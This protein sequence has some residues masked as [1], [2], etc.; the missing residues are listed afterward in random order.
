MRGVINPEEW[1]KVPGRWH[2][3]VEGARFGA[4]ISV[5]FF[6]KP[7]IGAAPA[8]IS[9]PIRKHSSSAPEGRCSRLQMK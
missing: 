1:A 3:E 9:T 2:G 6:S 7:Q 5:I 4:G 8:C